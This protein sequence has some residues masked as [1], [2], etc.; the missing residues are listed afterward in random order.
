M[1]SARESVKIF[2]GKTGMMQEKITKLLCFK[3]G[4]KQ[5]FLTT[6][7]FQTTLATTFSNMNTLFK[8]KS[9]QYTHDGTTGCGIAAKQKFL[10]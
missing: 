2:A 1:N 10:S 5:P 4:L 3:Q 8:V 9:L 7:R 6:C